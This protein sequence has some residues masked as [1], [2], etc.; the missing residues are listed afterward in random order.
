MPTTIEPPSHLPI[1]PSPHQE[2]SLCSHAYG[3]VLGAECHARN[4]LTINPSDQEEKYNLLFARVTGFLLIELFNERAIISAKPYA[5]LASEIM[6]LPVGGI[7]YDLVFEL[8]RYFYE[9]FKRTCA[10]GFSPIVQRLTFLTDRQSAKEYS[11]STTRLSHRFFD[12]GEDVTADSEG[13]AAARAQV[14]ISHPLRPSLFLMP[15]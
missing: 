11:T 12:N 14:R 5:S 7:A 8:G 4:Q 9:Y 13:C 3:I 10:F 6:S 1:R 2:W 15:Y